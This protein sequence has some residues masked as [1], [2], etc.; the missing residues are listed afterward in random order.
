MQNHS[1]EWMRRYHLDRVDM[2]MVYSDGQV[3]SATFAGRSD[4]SRTALWIHED[5][6][7]LTEG[8]DEFIARVADVLGTITRCLPMDRESLLH[9][10]QYGTMLNLQEEL[11]L[12]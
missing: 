2:A 8:D 7:G 4:L 5:V 10:L 12:F 9:C 6:I 3:I 11:P 1:E